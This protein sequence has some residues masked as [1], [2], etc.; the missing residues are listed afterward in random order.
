MPGYTLKHWI[1]KSSAIN[2]CKD[3]GYTIETARGIIKKLGYDIKTLKTKY[4]FTD[5]VLSE[6]FA[7][8]PEQ[9]KTLYL[10]IGRI[11]DDII[12]DEHG[13]RLS[14]SVYLWRRGTLNKFRC[15]TISCKILLDLV[16]FQSKKLIVYTNVE[17][18]RKINAR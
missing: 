17:R 10:I 2:I 9:Q 8:Y 3:N 11:L 16:N 15:Y 1:D 13:Y 4:Y 18:E 6:V 5:K 14:G 7:Y 12:Y